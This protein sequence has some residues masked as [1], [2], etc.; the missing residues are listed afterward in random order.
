MASRYRRSLI[1]TTNNPGVESLTR[2][3]DHLAQRDRR[4]SNSPVRHG[5]EYVIRA[6]V[7][8]GSLMQLAPPEAFSMPLAISAGTTPTSTAVAGGGRACRCDQLNFVRT[9]GGGFVAIGRRSRLA[10]WYSPCPGG[11]GDGAVALIG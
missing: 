10:A 9:S 11:S 8:R 5:V 4:R 3:K 7:L 1:M 6:L 2:I